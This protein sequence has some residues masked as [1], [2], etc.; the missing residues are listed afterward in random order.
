MNK[1]KLIKLL[2][3]VAYIGLIAVMV[4]VALLGAEELL[5]FGFILLPFTAISGVCAVLYFKLSEK[6]KKA[7]YDGA[8]FSASR[9]F[10]PYLLLFAILFVNIIIFVVGSI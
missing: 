3:V 5:P 9:I 1:A 6:E 10:H 2:R 4:T 7:V 8:V